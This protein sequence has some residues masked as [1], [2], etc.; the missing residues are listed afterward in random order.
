MMTDR[1][2]FLDTETTGLY[3]RNGDKVIE[4][5]CVE[6]V[7]GVRTGSTFQAYINPQREVPEE[8]FRVHGI[9]DEF[10]QDKPIFSK[11][12]GDFLAYISNSTLVIHNATFDINF[13]N[14][15]LGILGYPEIP[16]HRV[17]D[18]L[19]LARKK[20]PGAPASLDAL[21]KR[22]NI[23]LKNRDKHGALLDAELLASVYV[24]MTGGSQSSLD[25]GSTAQYNHKIQVMGSVAQQHPRRTFPLTPEEELQHH[26]MTKKITGS[27]WDS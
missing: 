17:I 24:E 15:E 7:A 13:L 4:I 2:I 26:E 12:V 3:P 23:S 8:A 25:L 10:L 22:F 1:K 21:C 11:I 16:M 18:T 14:Y 27:V 19:K 6:F 9:S 20:F 5:G